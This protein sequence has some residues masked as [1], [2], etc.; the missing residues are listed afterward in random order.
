MNIFIEGLQG[1]GKTTLLQKLSQK[2]PEYQVYREGDYCPIELAWCSY[3]TGEEYTDTIKRYPTLTEEIKQWT[4]KE[5]DRY[6]VAYTRIITD[7]P[8]FH[9]YMEQFEIYNGRKTLEE[10]EHIILK[11]YEKLSTED[12]GNIFECAFLQNIIEELILFHQMSDDQIY[13]FYSKLSAVA[14]KK[15][16]LLYYLYS[17]NIEE[18]IIQIKNERCDTNGN[19]LWY[20]VMLEY[21]QDSP[22]G[23]AHNFQEFSDMLNHFKHRQKLEMRII[24]EL[25]ADK[26]VILPAKKYT[27]KDLIYKTKKDE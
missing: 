5:E 27:D 16:F 24:K 25:F 7:E 8:Q 2:Y 10:F 9:K 13:S 14:S 17:E 20:S 12:R 4:R 18:Y 19:Q 21:L 26:T 15:K 1:M 6:I 22:Y 3:M 11:R 23:K